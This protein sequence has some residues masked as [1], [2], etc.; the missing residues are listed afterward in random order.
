[1]THQEIT[2]CEIKPLVISFHNFLTCTTLLISIHPCRSMHPYSVFPLVLA[3]KCHIHYLIIPLPAAFLFLQGKSLTVSFLLTHASKKIIGI[4]MSKGHV[5][6]TKQRFT[7]IRNWN[8]WV[9]EGTDAVLNQSRAKRGVGLKKLFISIALSSFPCYS[10]HL[11]WLL[12]VHSPI[13]GQRKCFLL[14]PTEK[15]SIFSDIPRR[16]FAYTT[17]QHSFICPVINFK[18]I[19]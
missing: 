4:E 2:V 14:S 13:W 11:T 10:F 12:S 1:M 3:F 9:N 7:P 17:V 8:Y 18:L 5:K 19:N 6:V 16:T 15:T